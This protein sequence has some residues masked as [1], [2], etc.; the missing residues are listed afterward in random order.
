MV[1]LFVYIHHTP[2]K[3]FHIHVYTV[4]LQRLRGN[5]CIYLE[6]SFCVVMEKVCIHE[7]KPCL[8]LGTSCNIPGRTQITLWLQTVEYFITSVI[9]ALRVKPE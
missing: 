5:S 4:L 1:L 2:P 7:S 6:E 9:N 3:Y 8:E